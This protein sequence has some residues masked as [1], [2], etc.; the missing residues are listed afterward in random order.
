MLHQELAMNVIAVFELNAP[1]ANS[2]GRN[3]SFPAPPRKN[4]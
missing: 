3:S 1:P 4:L 2:R